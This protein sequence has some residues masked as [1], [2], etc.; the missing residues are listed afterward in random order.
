MYRALITVNDPSTGKRLGK[1]SLQ[2]QTAGLQRAAE[3]WAWTRIAT[4]TGTPGVMLEAKYKNEFQKGIEAAIRWAENTG[5]G[6]EALT[7]NNP[8]QDALRG[9]AIKGHRA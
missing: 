3:A 6:I 7:T 4:R 5:F 9:L 1:V 2:R 8:S